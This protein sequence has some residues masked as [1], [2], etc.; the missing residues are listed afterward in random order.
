MAGLGGFNLPHWGYR[1][2]VADA[3]QVSQDGPAARSSRRPGSSRAPST[4]CA[5]IVSDPSP[6]QLEA[7]AADTSE[8]AGPAAPDAGAARLV[9]LATS[10]V[11]GASTPYRK[12]LA[13]ESY[14]TSPRF[15]YQLPTRT[16]RAAVA[17]P[18]PGYADLMS[19]LFNSRTGYC[20]QFATAFAVLARIDGL[21]T[22]IAVGFLPGTAGRSRPVAG[23]GDRHPRL[24]P[25]A[26]REIRLDRLRADARRD[27]DGLVGSS[28]PRPTDADDD[29]G[30]DVDHLDGGAQPPPLER[31]RSGTPGAGAEP[32]SRTAPG[33][34]SAPWLLVCPVRAAGLGGRRAGCGGGLRLRRAAAR[35][36]GGGPRRLGRGVRTLDLAGIRR[37]RAE[38]Y[39]E[40]ARRVVSTG[41]L[42][43]EAE[44]ALRDLA[45]LAT[46]ASYAASPPGRPV[47]VGR[48]RDARR[49]CEA[50][51]GGS[52][53]GSG[54]WRRS[55]RES[56]R[57]ERTAARP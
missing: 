32:I 40:L 9:R 15:R 13:I 25:G 6:A 1:A 21:P 47:L 48:C 23:R 29:P 45:R 5:S 43:D 42:S 56:F 3:G 14:L 35:A 39:L 19:F 49:S 46:A 28:L 53:A 55:T 50:P 2:L 16:N 7:V 34:S 24:A 38:T 11:A 26:V 44:L 31:R 20:Q 54:S 10:L 8:P 18:S 27:R 41:V 30:P 33:G 17:S 4:P 36:A 51:G 57:R 37:R 52:R 12:A 22:R